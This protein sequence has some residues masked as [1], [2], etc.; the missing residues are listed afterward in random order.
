MISESYIKICIY[1]SNVEY[2]YSNRENMESVWKE[3]KYNDFYFLNVGLKSNNSK[4]L[5]LARYAE[6]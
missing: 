1:D 2:F 5:F 3:N 6:I 4:K